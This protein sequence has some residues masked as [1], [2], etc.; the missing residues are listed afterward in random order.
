MTRL[1]NNI[2]WTGQNIFYLKG[3][4]QAAASKKAVEDMEDGLQVAVLA[5]NKHGQKRD[6][7]N[8]QLYLLHEGGW[9]TK[10]KGKLRMRNPS[11]QNTGGVELTL[12]AGNRLMVYIFWNG[13]TQRTEITLAPWVATHEQA[14]ELQQYLS[15][16][17]LSRFSPKSVCGRFG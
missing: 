5:L 11:P 3:P 7:R 1:V 10:G 14:G 8:T 9:K 12:A 13:L 4:D 15:E 6:I 16:E 2:A 17:R